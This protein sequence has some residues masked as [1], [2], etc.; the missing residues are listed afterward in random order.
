M[1]TLPWSWYVIALVAI[2][3]A[4]CVWLIRWTGKRRPGDPLPTQTSHTWDGDL[5]EYNQPMPR[6]WI[7][8]FYLTILFAIGYLAWY[9]GLGAFTGKGHWTSAR[10]HDAD[11]SAADAKLAALFARFEGVP[12]D[13]LARDPEAVRYGQSVF[14][15]RCAACHGSDAR[16]AK[17][18]PDLTDAAWQWG[19]TPDRIFESVRQGRDAVMPPLGAA[20]GEV[21]T[22]EVAVYVQSLS[23]QPV[24]PALRAAG[25]RR[26]AAV[27]AACHGPDGKGNALLGA[28][29]LTD[30]AWLYGGD[31]ASLR[32]SISAGRAGHMPAHAPLI[33]ETRARLAA[34]FV[35]S[36][37]NA[38]PAPGAHAAGSAP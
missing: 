18:Y 14:A 27:C 19:G 2:N 34:A 11:R 23:H 20:L 21:G 13:R 16:G 38:T 35:Y 25:E 1:M 10:E 30:D 31:Y 15:N 29:D 24:D 33:G 4:G 9:P 22:T 5:T 7:N 36:K 6:W 12:I 17:G 32:E 8:L 3:L 28:P 26:F 37:A